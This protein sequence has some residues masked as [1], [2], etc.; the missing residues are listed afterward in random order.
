[1]RK[2]GVHREGGAERRGTSDSARPS[3]KYIDE[4]TDNERRCLSDKIV[5]GVD[6]GMDN[7]LYFSTEDGTKRKR[8]TQ[9]QRRKETKV[10]KYDRRLVKEKG[11]TVV[12]GRTI[13]QWEAELS[14][15]SHKTVSLAAF[16]EYIC[17]KLW[18]NSKIS[19]FYEKRWHRKQRLNGYFNRCRSE[20]RLLEQLEAMFGAPKD[21][22]IGIGDW[23]QWKHRKYKEP[24]KGKGFRQT[25]RRGGYRVFL[26]DEHRTSLQCSLCQ[27]ENAKCHK[28]LPSTRRDRSGRSWFV[29]G[30]L[31]CQQCR[32]PRN[33]DANA[34]MNIARLTRTALAG[35]SRPEYLQ[36]SCIARK[37][38][39]GAE[40]S[41]EKASK[42]PFAC[43]AQEGWLNNA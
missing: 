20:S 6:P 40:S 41:D 34:S 19:A 22:V 7:L 11:K 36:R 21:V 2:D 28:F 8:Y 3:E 15:H 25:L 29:H 12:D 32:R 14:A 30:L 16:K 17:A 37:R 35:L 38:K 10:R 31:L 4:L 39:G 5:V 33:R 26:V 43:A 24:V 23:E 9:R 27:E 18:M 42:K 1:V 13:T